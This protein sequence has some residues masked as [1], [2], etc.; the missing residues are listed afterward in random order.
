MDAVVLVAELEGEIGG[1][2]AGLK[3][4]AWWYEGDQVANL[5]VY[6]RPD[7]R[8]GHVGVRL[9]KR[10]MD[11]ASGWDSVKQVMAGSSMG[12]E[13]GERVDGFYR[14]FGFNKTGGAYTR[15]MT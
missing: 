11:W 12:G 2:V 4:P 6:V 3:V 10:Y 13:I 14:R 15:V 9:F 1:V 8:G 5:V 7:W